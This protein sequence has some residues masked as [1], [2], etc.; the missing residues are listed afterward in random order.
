MST[1]SIVSIPSEIE[2]LVVCGATDNTKEA[3]A[4]FMRCYLSSIENSGTEKTDY[5]KSTTHLEKLWKE[6]MNDL[7]NNKLLVCSIFSNNITTYAFQSLVNTNASF[8]LACKNKLI[9]QIFYSKIPNTVGGTDFCIKHINSENEESDK[10]L[11][12][13]FQNKM[14]TTKLDRVIFSNRKYFTS[15]VPKITQSFGQVKQIDYE[16][17][18]PYGTAETH[19]FYC[20]I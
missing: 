1:P 8:N 6:S 3:K 4:L 11:K 19:D 5:V 15:F 2:D 18:F 16:D 9:G 14:R 10:F 12:L 13:I 20:L 17:H 7:L